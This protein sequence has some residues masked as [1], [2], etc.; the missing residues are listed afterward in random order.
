[1]VNIAESLRII[2]KT[3]G[4]HNCPASIPRRTVG[5]NPLIN[6]VISQYKN[7]SLIGSYFFCVTALRALSTLFGCVVARDTLADWYHM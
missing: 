4:D 3:S 1:M 6:K 2:G 7:L 5:L